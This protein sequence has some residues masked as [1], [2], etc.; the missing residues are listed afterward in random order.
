MCSGQKAE[1]AL[2]W[3]PGPAGWR[4]R[5]RARARLWSPHT[6]CSRWCGLAD[7]QVEIR[8]SRGAPVWRVEDAGQGVADRHSS[9][10][11]VDDEAAQAASGGSVQRRR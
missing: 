3:Q 8:S 5:C 7:G 2:A 11:M 1:W 6:L 10:M 4:E 9:R